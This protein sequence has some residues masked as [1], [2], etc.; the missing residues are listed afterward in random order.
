MQQVARGQKFVLFVEINADQFVAV[1]LNRQLT[2]IWNAGYD[3]SSLYCQCLFS[4][5]IVCH[6]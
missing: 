3:G 4:F 6:L 1:G 2:S 5:L